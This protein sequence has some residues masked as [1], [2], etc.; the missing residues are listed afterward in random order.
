MPVLEHRLKLV[1][2]E[3]EELHVTTSGSNVS[4]YVSD[5]F[6]RASMKLSNRQLKQL[7]ATLEHALAEE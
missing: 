2:K 4:V 5:K 1:N 7:I 6:G 3:R